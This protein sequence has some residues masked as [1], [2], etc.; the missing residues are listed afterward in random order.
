MRLEVNQ[1]ANRAGDQVND[2]GATFQ[3]QGYGGHY[4]AVPRRTEPGVAACS[5]IM[6]GLRMFDIRD[7]YHPR[8]IAYANFPTNPTKPGELASSFAMSAPA[9][10][11]ERG[12]VWYADGNSGFYNLHITNGVWPFRTAGTAPAQATT[13]A[14]TGNER[15]GIAGTQLPATGGSAPAGIGVVALA[16]GIGLQ[17]MRRRL[18][19]C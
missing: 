5:F 7:P 8:E 1:P 16:G 3:V 17:R 15:P 2:P 9:F 14:A 10:A 4:C 6:S 19:R 11:P 18:A 13:V 12:E